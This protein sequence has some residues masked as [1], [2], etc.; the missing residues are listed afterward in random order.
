MRGVNHFILLAEKLPFLS[1]I[2]AKECLL[3]ITHQPVFGRR[4]CLETAISAGA[5]HDARALQ[6][7]KPPVQQ[8]PAAPFPCWMDQRAEPFPRRNLRGKPVIIDKS[9]LGFLGRNEL[10]LGFA[11]G[12]RSVHHVGSGMNSKPESTE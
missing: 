11:V 10:I 3:H 5:G 9:L 12:M 1:I 6:G 8:R 2:E 4:F 7:G